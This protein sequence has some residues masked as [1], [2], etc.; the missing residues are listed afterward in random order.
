MHSLLRVTLLGA[1]LACLLPRPAGSQESRN[2]DFWFLNNTGKT[3]REVYVSP[4]ESKSWGQDVLGRS[5]LADGVGTLITFPSS[6]QTSCT[7][8]FKIVFEG[9]DS[10]TYPDGRNV[11]SLHAVQFDED[12]SIG[13]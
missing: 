6:W 11:C 2:R 13:F 9:G 12:T 10:Q 3:I 8:D 5:T 7:M 1:L 4:H